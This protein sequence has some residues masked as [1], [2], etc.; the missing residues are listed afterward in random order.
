[1]QANCIASLGLVYAVPWLE[2]LLRELFNHDGLR[3]DLAKGC[4]DEVYVG[5]GC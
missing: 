3:E 5:N 2:D 4:E 1:M